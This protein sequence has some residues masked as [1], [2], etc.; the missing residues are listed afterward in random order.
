MTS[1]GELSGN[2][3]SG[4]FSSQRS[5]ECNNCHTNSRDRSNDCRYGSTITQPIRYFLI[6][7]WSLTPQGYLVN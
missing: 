2:N 1:K 6:L 5:H 4:P 3:I 7:H